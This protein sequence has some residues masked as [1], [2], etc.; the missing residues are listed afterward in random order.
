MHVGMSKEL[1]ALV[2]QL[3]ELLNSPI[4]DEDDAL[5]VAIVA[6]LA[7]R[8]GAAPEA[9]VAAVAWREGPGA[10]L[11]SEMWEQ[12]D[13]APLVEAVDDCTGG[14]H[15]D[16]EI[17]EALYDVDE[18]I[19]AAVWCGQADRVRGAARELATIIRGVPDVFE[20]LAH[21]G[22]Q[23]AA[24]QAVGQELFLYDYWMALADVVES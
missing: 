4:V 7:A 6:G 13:L 3:D 10:D 16:E 14:G 8:E 19:A 2:E 5:E 9:L 22:R 24:S 1:D 12:V 17:E 21:E 11:L 23:M 15:S 20:P 18:V